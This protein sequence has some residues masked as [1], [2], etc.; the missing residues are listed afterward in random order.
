MWDAS[1]LQTHQ[2]E[3][4]TVDCECPL[5]GSLQVTVVG[6][7]VTQVLRRDD[8]SSAYHGVEGASGYTIEDLFALVAQ[9]KTNGELNRVEF[10][11]RLGYPTLIDVGP[12]ASDAHIGFQM[13]SFTKA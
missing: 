2:Y 5:A 8:R 10:D 1:G 6:A 9:A 3:S 4:T 7:V 12:A 11:A 13:T